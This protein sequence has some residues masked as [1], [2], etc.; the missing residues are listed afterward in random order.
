MP[1]AYYS[2]NYWLRLLDIPPYVA[3]RPEAVLQ[4]AY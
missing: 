4:P 3:D 2:E 1:S